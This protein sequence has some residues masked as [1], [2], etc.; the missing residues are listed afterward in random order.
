MAYRYNEGTFGMDWIPDP[1]DQ[2]ATNWWNSITGQNEPS[3]TI[4][5]QN[6]GNHGSP[7][8]DRL[9]QEGW[10][11]GAL[12]EPQQEDFLT[13]YGPMII[14]S[15]AT[16]GMGGMLP[17][18]ESLFGGAGLDTAGLAAADASAGLIPAGELG[19]LTA[20]P[21]A[22]NT[23]SSLANVG[24]SALPEAGSVFG[25]GASTFNPAT[26]SISDIV[27][28]VSASGGNAIPMSALTPELAAAATSGATISSLSPSL[29]SQLANTVS[30]AT[31]TP[32]TGSQLL[33]S[34]LQA[35][36]SLASGYMGANAAENAAN[37]Q[38]AATNSA[39]AEQRRQYDQ[40]RTDML[41]WLTAGSSAVN[42]L[43]DLLGVSSNNTTTGYGSLTKPFGI[44]D[45]Q[46]DPGYQFRLNQ[47][48]EALQRS[49]GARGMLNSGNRLMELTKYGQDM[50][51]QEYQNAY[52]R[53]NSNQTNT[54]NRLAGLSGT[55]Q[56]SANT[57]ANSG[58]N[59]ANS[60]S[61]LL[62]NQGNANAAAGIAGTN[63]WTSGLTGVAGAVSNYFGN[64]QRQSNFD[65]IF[66]V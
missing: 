1:S 28:A 48:Q 38:S 62:T 12:I 31:G 6:A 33:S 2:G 42:R 7:V 8:F 60:L 32:I 25:T 16:A 37:T 10:R 5:L 34:G 54:Y 45:Y 57:L 19:A 35:G 22:T 47:G 41:P 50:G 58:S 43:S 15:L 40:N 36:A 18:T 65:R 64:Q 9:W 53:Y 39:I 51:T 29:L 44:A 4:A 14:A 26:A 59:T 52:N 55:G 27:S 30:N 56:T 24:P 61:G 11:R 3:L 66:G 46:E 63:A 23:L 17:G 13:Q 20:A 49:L 21:A